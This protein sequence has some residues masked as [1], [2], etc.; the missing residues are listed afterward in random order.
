MKLN[1][2]PSGEHRVVIDDAQNR[3]S[4]LNEFQV[5]PHPLAKFLSKAL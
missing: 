3:I 5:S 2:A 1:Q 4:V